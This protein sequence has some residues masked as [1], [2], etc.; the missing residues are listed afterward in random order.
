[1]PG[2]PS[3]LH[4]LASALPTNRLGLATW[5]TGDANPLLARVAVNRWWAEIF[6]RGIVPTLGDFGAKGEPPTHP[7]LLDYLAI[8]LRQ[9]GWS[10][11]RI[12]RQ[13]VPS[14]AYQQSSRVPAEKLAADPDNIY[15]SRAPRFRMP[16]EMLRDNALSV[17]GLLAEKMYGAPVFPPQPP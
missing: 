15:L 4:L 11:N 8:E 17:S 6:G 9:A 7:Q 5:L 2:T 12:L 3:A 14:R 1:E 13:T 10:M 16:A